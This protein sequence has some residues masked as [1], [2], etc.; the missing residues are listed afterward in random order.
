MTTSETPTTRVG[1]IEIPLPTKRYVPAVSPRLRKWLYVIFALV[2]LL[3]ANAAYLGGITALEAITKQTYQDY[4]YQ[5]MFLVHLVL[6]VLLIVPFVLFGVFH[7]VASRK[8]RNRRAVRIG[9]AL[10]T[11]GI[12]VLVSGILLMRIGGFNIRDGNGVMFVSQSGDVC[13]AGFLPL[14]HPNHPEGGMLFPKV[15]IDEV[16]KQGHIDTLTKEQ[17]RKIIQ[18]LFNG[19]TTGSDEAKCMNLLN[20]APD[21]DVQY[22]IRAIGWGRCEDE[23][24]DKFSKKY[25]K[26]KYGGK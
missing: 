26:A 25:P 7:M 21:P 16:K 10:F 4:F 2:A 15:H 20:T 1:S 17:R 3:G 19:L 12:V 23:L 6:G 13:P 24:G 14:P 5:Y 9:Y 22:I 8:R 11:A 18:N